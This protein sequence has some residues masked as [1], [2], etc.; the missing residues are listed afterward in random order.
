MRFNYRKTIACVLLAVCITTM[1]EV[2]K[3]DIIPLP[4]KVEYHEG[5]YKLNDGWSADKVKRV[6]D[7]TIP[8]E[9][10]RIDVSK[11]G[12]TIKASSSVGFFYGRQT[13]LQIQSQQTAAGDDYLQNLTIV[14][15]PRFEYRGVMLDVVRCYLPKSEIL[16]II[17]VASSL[18]LN[19]LHL[20][21]TDD[22]GWRMEIKKY[23]KLTQVGAWRV[24]RDTYF[25]NRENP[26]ADEPTPVG[27]IYTQKE[28]KEIVK[29]AQQHG[30]TVIP[31][32]EMPAHSVA[33]IA[34]YPEMTCPVIG[35]RF[36]GVLPGIGGKDASIIYCAGNDKVF[37]F[38]QNILDEV[39]N[40]FPSEYIHIGGD[41]AE[42][43]HWKRC[44][45]C[46]KRM[47]E[48]GI[49]NE[50]LLQGY[51]MDRM[52]RY[53]NSKGRKAIG[54]DEVT[55]GSP[56]EDITIFGWRGNG[57]AAIK[58]A[59][60]NKHRFVLT[61]AQKLYLIRYQGPQWF[62]PYTYFG[63]NTLKDVFNYEPVKTDWTP[64][65]ENLLWGTQ[66]SLWT[67]FCKDSNAVEYLLFPRLIAHAD[68]AW[69]EKNH[70][71]WEGFLRGLDHFLPLL[72]K[73]SV[74]YA[75]SMY[76][77]Q[78]KVTPNGKGMLN[79][80]LECERPDVE[81]KRLIDTRDHIKAATFKDGNQMG[82]TLDLNFCQSK[83]RGCKVNAVNCTNGLAGVLT[84]GL[85]GTDRHSDFEWAGWYNTD[86]EFVIDMEE[87]TEINTIT[88]GT[89]ANC[90]MTVAAPLAV[91]AY[92][93]ND[94][95]TFRLLSSQTLSEDTVYAKYPTKTDVTLTF[96]G[97]KYSYIKIKAIHPG[98]IPDNYLRGSQSPWIYFDEVIVN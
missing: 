71:D 82:E 64:E 2:R 93:S 37:T 39:M 62:E 92:G 89:L 78:H 15:K 95:K 48:A 65:L 7:S 66:A 32:I 77:I 86:A 74:N 13:L 83:A 80:N 6:K 68:N 4:A 50:E 61:P 55:M 42:K 81:I 49:D 27:G 97:A 45:L 17:D 67:E 40:V 9:G 73:M 69:R 3:Y 38:L 26:A 28:L 44:E 14:D 8:K 31:E 53:L 18:K 88:V 70:S 24:E 60:E 36:I 29:Y 5:V 10:Y 59:K 46:Q 11:D 22:N 51:F 84:N 52:I 87:E 75:K 41:E 19:K 57:Q 98:V 90:N 85:R 72:D 35:N 33:A 54:W 94:N 56:K 63:N 30:M 47:Q 96:S 91:Y 25:Q 1:A 58:D 76:N 16:K 12:V 34:S 43:S 79:V 20:H 21:L 23:P